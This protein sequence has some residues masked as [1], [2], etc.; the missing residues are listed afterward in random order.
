[1]YKRSIRKGVLT[2]DKMRI[3][4][5]LIIGFGEERYKKVF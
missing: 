2:D 4:E 3:F 1:M 5:G